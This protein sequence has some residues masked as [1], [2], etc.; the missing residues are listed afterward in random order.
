MGCVRS[1]N[2]PPGLSSTDITDIGHGEDVI[3]STLVRAP[4]SD[5]TTILGN[6]LWA[7]D[8]KKRLEDVRNRLMKSAYH[9][10]WAAE[11]WG[12][13]GP[14]SSLAGLVYRQFNRSKVLEILKQTHEKILEER[15]KSLNS[16][17][18]I[19]LHM[20]TSFKQMSQ[21]W[22]LR[23]FKTK[24]EL[25]TSTY[26]SM[27]AFIGALVI[28]HS[29]RVEQYA[30]ILK[31]RAVDVSKDIKATMEDIWRTVNCWDVAWIF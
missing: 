27:Q 19:N 1:R 6:V 16:S 10:T 28:V 18:T 17:M 21:T 7:W 3:R 14:S 26:E 25:S 12:R 13:S 8:E 30:F 23:H 31:S 22:G 2:D 4:V 9:K 15:L 20:R 5:V 29:V 24:A 11:L